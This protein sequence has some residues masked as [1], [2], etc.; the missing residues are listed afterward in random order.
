M[1]DDFCAEPGRGWWTWGSAKMNLTSARPLRINGLVACRVIEQGY[2]GVQDGS[3]HHDNQVHCSG[4]YAS[5]CWSNVGGVLAIT[6]C[7]GAWRL[8]REDS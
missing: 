3:F 8:F 2:A 6:G 7:S 4:I 5:D 1:F